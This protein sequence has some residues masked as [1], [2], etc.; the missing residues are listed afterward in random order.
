ME[1]LI[2]WIQFSS[3]GASIFLLVFCLF[4]VRT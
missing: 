4:A 1:L 3:S 2:R